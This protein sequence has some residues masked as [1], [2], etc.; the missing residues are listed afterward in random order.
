VDVAG[1]TIGEIG[2]GL[3]VLVCAERGD[4]EAQADKLLAKIPQAAHLRR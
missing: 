2:A 3:L 1:Q 4:S